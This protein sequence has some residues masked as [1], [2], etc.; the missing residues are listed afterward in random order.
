M[1]REFDIAEWIK[2][3]RKKCGL[4]QESLGEKLGKTKGNVS[5]WENGRHEPSFKQIAQIGEITKY[6]LPKDINVRI[7]RPANALPHIEERANMDQI[8]ELLVLCQQLDNE[9]MDLILDFA[10]STAKY[11]VPSWIRRAKD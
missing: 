2:E 9:D 3:A 8:I 5:A 1:E 6:P 11:V 4:S 7:I 10:R